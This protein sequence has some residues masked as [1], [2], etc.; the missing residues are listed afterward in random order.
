MNIKLDFWSIGL[1][2]V[3][4]IIGI[5]FIYSSSSNLADNSKYLKQMINLFISLMAYMFV[6]NINYQR[7]TTKSI[8]V[9]GAGILFLLLTLALGT[10]I[11]NSRSWINLGF[12]N[13][14][15]SEFSKVTFLVAFAVFLNNYQNNIKRFYFL[16]VSFV[17]LLPYLMLIV[18]QPDIGTAVIFVIIFFSMFFMGGGN[19]SY[20]GI[21]M[22]IGLLSDSCGGNYRDVYRN[23]GQQLLPDSNGIYG[24]GSRRHS[25]FFLSICPIIQKIHCGID[26]SSYHRI[27]PFGNQRGETS[28]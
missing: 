1:A 8:L 16:M 19:G 2:L 28:L 13:I 23:N 26:G 9:Y 6:M 4:S 10:S 24:V 11:N 20:L 21:T 22:G 15:L 3:L 14:Q 25:L 17:L 18:L 12:F 27:R 7:Y 5:L